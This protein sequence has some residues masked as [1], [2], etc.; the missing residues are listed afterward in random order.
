MYKITTLLALC[1]VFTLSSCAVIHHLLPGEIKAGIELVKW[2]LR[3]KKTCEILVSKEMTK[4]PK[5]ICALPPAK[6]KTGA[7]GVGIAEPLGNLGLQ[8]E[9]AQIGGRLKIAATLQAQIVANVRGEDAAATRTLR[10]SFEQY[11]EG[12]VYGSHELA[13]FQTADGTIY[14]LMAITDE[15]KIKESAESMIQRVLTRDR[16]DLLGCQGKDRCASASRK[17]WKEIDDST[18]IEGIPNN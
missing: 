9:K 10:K 3:D 2:F 7:Y 4:V 11:I 5:W 17:L 14:S 16:R 13:N 8:Y 15:D 6:N 18:T 1:T 12:T